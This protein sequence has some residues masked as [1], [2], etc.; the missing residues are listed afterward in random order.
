MISII[1]PT[2]NEEKYLPILLECI[3]KQTSKN[4]EIIVADA[5]STDMTLKIARKYGCRI[6][7]GGSPAVGRNNGAKVAKNN[8]LLFLDADVQ[9]D[10]NFL[11][12][13]I[14][15]FKKRKLDIAGVFLTPL[16]NKLIDRIFISIFNLIIFIVQFFCPHASGSS[17]FCR[18]WLYNRV[19]GFDKTVKLGE[20]LDYIHRCS[21]L[22]KFRILKRVRVGL[23]MRRFDKEGRIKV[24]TRHLMSTLYRIF[25]GQIR[26]DV[27]KYNL[28]Y[29]K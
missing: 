18:K 3:K 14:N 9:F 4:Y 13:A 24:G 5:N 21:K 29:Q 25:F 8:I 7:K 28:R 10:N 6:V 17:I 2:W 19:K 11:K 26:I 27:F 23:S 22:G 15:E 1:I 20:E 16:S 12:K